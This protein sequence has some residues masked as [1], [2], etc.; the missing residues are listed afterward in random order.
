[1]AT[2]Y[3]LLGFVA[4]IAAPTPAAATNTRFHHFFPI[5]NDYFINI[6]ND[7]CATLYASQQA[8]T[9]LYSTT[10][11]D[12]LSC[13]LANTSEAVKGNMASASVALGLMPTI[14]TFLGSSTAEVALLS[15][16]RP[17]LAVMIALGSPA[18][19]PLPTFV[20]PNPV[21][22]LK[23]REGRLLLNHLSALS[24]FRAAILI[25]TEYLIVIAAIVN[26]TTASYY[27]GLWT[28]TNISCSTTW[29][30]IVWVFVTICLHLMGML[31]LALRA[32]TIRGAGTTR[33]IKARVTEWIQHEFKPCITHEKLAL[34]WKQENIAF[35]FV[36]WLTSIA[37]VVHLLYG[38][39]AFSSLVFIGW[40]DS[41]QIIA[42]FMASAIIC[43]AVLMFE[44]AGMRNALF[45]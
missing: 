27:T 12:L 30:P 44:L 1:M 25:L 5:Y 2:R 24:N 8:A 20:Y 29:Y 38:T 6:R 26:V 42:R 33:S 10:C 7:Q 37:T 41:T 45:T 31:S 14:L 36:S 35:I 39:I 22:D 11:I 15:R 21:A 3:F 28:I 4:F 18:V 13:I 16:R 43:R 9:S 40:I 17:L 19:N 23:E 34:N 32:E